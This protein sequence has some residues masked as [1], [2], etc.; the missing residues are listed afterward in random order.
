MNYSLPLV[1]WNES[2]AGNQHN[3]GKFGR[4][5]VHSHGGQGDCNVLI[6]GM[7]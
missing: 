1:V 3:L 2:T 7:W 5:T 6:S 4:V